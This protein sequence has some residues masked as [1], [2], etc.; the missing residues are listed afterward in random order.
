MFY[1]EVRRLGG[2]PKSRLMACRAEGRDGTRLGG[3]VKTY[4]PLGGCR[5]RVDLGVV[6]C[7]PD[8]AA[9]AADL[10]EASGF[11]GEDHDP[12][13]GVGLERR[14]RASSAPESWRFPNEQPS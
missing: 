12:R 9:S 5:G 13:F 1:K 3:C 8:A 10:W 7:V 4:I 11:E 2:I 14:S 6:H